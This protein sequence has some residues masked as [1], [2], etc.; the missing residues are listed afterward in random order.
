[1]MRWIFMAVF[2]CCSRSWALCPPLLPEPVRIKLQLGQ[3]IAD[4]E[5]SINEMLL[6]TPQLQLW[7]LLQGRLRAQLDLTSAGLPGKI[8]AQPLIE[9]INLDGLAD[10]LWL[11]STEGQLW[12][13]SL[14][15]SQLQQPRLMA[16]LSDSGLEFIATAGLLRTRLPSTLAPLA[17]RQA[18]QQL[19]LLIARDRVSGHD[20]LFM[21]RF[22]IN[23][24]NSDVIHFNQLLDRTILSEAEQGQTLAAADWR[25]LLSNAGW[26]LQLPGKVS[27]TPKVVA[28]VIYAPVAKT[29]QPDECT[30]EASEQALYALQLHT[31]A[32]IYPKRSQQIPYIPEAKLALRQQADKS[33]SLV[34]R[35]EEQSTLLLSNLL[36]ISTECHTCTEPLSLEQFPLWQRLATYRSEQGAY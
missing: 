19:V 5:V 16:D 35:L 32:Q 14:Q 22:A 9:D 6:G 28:G 1:M 13:L 29:N 2:L 12:R 10:H 33:L 25:T 20:S 23:Q 11:M 21:L 18:D 8:Q 31:A 4:T 27:T 30:S 26:Q 7:D 15:G 3:Q 36:K 17:W 34:L 24:L